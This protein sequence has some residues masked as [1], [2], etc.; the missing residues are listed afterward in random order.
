MLIM[1]K[2]YYRRFRQ[3][4][5]RASAKRIRQFAERAF[6]YGT[7]LDEI[8]DENLL[9]WLRGRA[10]TAGSMP[11]IYQ[12][13]VYWFQENRAVTIYLL[14]YEYRKVCEK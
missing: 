14:P 13:Y 8:K 5:A 1:T 10:N 7:Q 9:F 12:N 3:R 6:A 11:R 4:V 2:H